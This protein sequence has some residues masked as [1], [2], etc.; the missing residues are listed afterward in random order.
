M[1]GRQFEQ[2]ADGLW[3]L[4]GD[5]G[6][7]FE[8]DK[9]ASGL[10]T[11]TPFDGFVVT[12]LEAVPGEYPE[13][14]ALSVLRRPHHADDGAEVSFDCESR[15]PFGVPMMIAHRYKLDAS[16]LAVQTSFEMPHAFELRS[17]AAGGLRF[18]GDVAEYSIVKPPQAEGVVKEPAIVPLDAPD[19]TELYRG[20]TPPLALNLRLS[21][22]RA[23]RFETGKDVW[24]WAN[25][26]R[27]GDG[28]STFIIRRE[29]ADLVYTWSLYAFA[30]SSPDT[31]PPPGRNWN[32]T[33]SLQWGGPE[34]S[35]SGGPFAD[36]FDLRAECAECACAQGVENA[37]KKW[38]RTRLA[39]AG[40]GDVFA[41]SVGGGRFCRRAGHLDRGRKK[42]LPHWDLPALRE[43]SRWA[44]RQLR[45]SGAKLVLTFGEGD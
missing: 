34:D 1:N 3:R 15:I 31:P 30:P 14:M 22:G 4:G 29:G 16:S 21:D 12:S 44:N 28:S 2:T 27:I 40:E 38:V 23:V 13:S 33:W 5:G 43:F 7:G 17:L 35:G 25:A 39:S 19:G 26:A 37:L 45:K 18:H 36:V 20:A 42:D 41:V 32:I 24:R 6:P 8:L 9:P 11:L 10:F